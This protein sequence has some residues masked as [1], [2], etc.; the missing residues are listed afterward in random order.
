M[1]PRN[2]RYVKIAVAV[3]VIVAALG[4]FIH[5]NG[6][7]IDPTDREVRVIVTGSMDGPE[8]PYDIPTIPKGSLVMVKHLSEDEILS[9]EVGDVISF[10]S[11]IASEPIHHRVVS[12]DAENRTV[13][14]KGDAYTTTETSSF[15]DVVGK[16]VGVD[17]YAGKAILFIK[18]NLFLVIVTILILT[19]L[20]YAVK[21]LIDEKRRDDSQ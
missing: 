8:Q 20:F 2:E 14:T 11:G 15:D 9:L 13:T 5:L 16:V 7:S 17:E 19:V 18:Q 3:I 12:I 1:N 4:F 6:G 21:A 10:R